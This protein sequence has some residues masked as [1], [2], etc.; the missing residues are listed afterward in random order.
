MRI[1][2]E[3]WRRFIPGVRMYRGKKTLFYN[4]EIIRRDQITDTRNERDSWQVI[5][6]LPGVEVIPERTFYGCLRVEVVIMADT[7]KRIE[8]QAFYECRSL[9]FIKL[10]KNLEY[11]GEL[12]FYHCN[13]LTSIFIP[14]SCIEIARD[15]FRCCKELIIFSVPQTT[16][17]GVNVVWDTALIRA[18]PFGLN[19]FGGY[20]KEINSRVNNWLKN[21]HNKYPLHKLC[22][23][24]QPKPDL[25]IHNNINWFQKDGCGLMPVDYFIANYGEDEHIHFLPRYVQHLIKNRK[26][27]VLKELSTGEIIARQIMYLESQIVEKDE[28]ISTFEKGRDYGMS[29]KLLEDEIKCCLCT[30][31]FSTD[32]NSTLPE[33]RRFLPV[34]SRAACPH[35]F[36]KGC[37]EQTQL[38]AADNAPQNKLPKWLKCMICKRKTAFCPEDPFYHLKLIEL[39]ERARRLHPIDVKVEEGQETIESGSNSN[40]DRPSKRQKVTNVAIKKEME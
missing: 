19:Q 25:Q 23:N 11:I 32:I 12:T 5:M 33:I 14:Q 1:Q 28:I 24:E 16:E 3:E 26:L 22:C 27:D 17:L 29:V 36:C 10:S 20:E 21:R 37:I 31:K 38:A 4:G 9:F 7:V 30:N 35:Y 8:N 6:V 39:L 34:L 2:T 15:A 40:D 18:S 13:S